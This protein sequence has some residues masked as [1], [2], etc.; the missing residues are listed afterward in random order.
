MQPHLFSFGYFGS[1]L[2]D[3]ISERFTRLINIF[4]C[5][6]SF[7]PFSRSSFCVYILHFRCV[8]LMRQ[9]HLRSNTRADTNRDKISDRDRCLC[10]INWFL[11]HIFL[12]K[13]GSSVPWKW[14]VRCMGCTRKY[15]LVPEM[16]A[17][18]F[19]YVQKHQTFVQNTVH[20]TKGC[21]HVTFD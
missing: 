19:Q 9:Q 20:L 12:R 14:P 18:E 13:I 2:F 4:Y 15:T 8:E 10:G 16:H 21:A 11:S 3:F 1:E 7:S 5:F 6:F 17:I